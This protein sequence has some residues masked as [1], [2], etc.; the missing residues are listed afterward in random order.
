MRRDGGDGESGEGGAELEEA[1]LSPRRCRVDE[2]SSPAMDDPTA[3]LATGLP[4]EKSLFGAP[5]I[6]ALDGHRL[7]LL[8]TAAWKDA[9]W[10]M[11]VCLIWIDGV[12]RNIAIP[13]TC[14][15]EQ[16]GR[17]SEV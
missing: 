14:S 17:A 2:E 7:V 12:G 1:S 4:G 10:L 16:R 8:L 9:L 5:L 13:S 11:T 15:L 6:L 3:P